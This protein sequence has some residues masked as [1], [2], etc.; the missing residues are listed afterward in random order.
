MRGEI[1]MKMIILFSALTILNV[2]IQTIKSLCT[3]KCSTKVS[4]CVNALAYGLYTFVIFYTTADGMSLWLKALITAI[5]NLIGVVVANN[6]FDRMFSHEVQWKVEVSVPSVVSPF[7]EDKMKEKKLEWYKCGDNIKWTAYAV[8]CP[9]KN[10]S[11]ALNE[12]MPQDAK[13]NVVE[14]LK[15]L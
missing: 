15:R 10:A 12:I 4:A 14:C 2:V 11:R 6:L 1:Q 13:Y 9:N 8:F 3:V 5:A 7:F